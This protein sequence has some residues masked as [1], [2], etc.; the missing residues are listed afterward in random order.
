MDKVVIN[1]SKKEKAKIRLE[2][3]REMKDKIELADDS[4]VNV[5]QDSRLKQKLFETELI[6]QKQE[7]VANLIRVYKNNLISL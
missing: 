7:F 1:M 6:Q 3:L 4:L 5:I 2:A